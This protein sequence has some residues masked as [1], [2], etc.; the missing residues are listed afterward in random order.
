[1]PTLTVYETIMYSA[2]LRLPRH[3]SYEDKKARV[4][5]TMVEL[6]ILHIA[7]RRIGTAG[8]RGIS[9]GEKRRVSIACELVT[10]ASVLF[11]DEPT[12]GE[13]AS[14]SFNLFAI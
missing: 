3:M 4:M 6:D 12:S 8:S 13:F 7:N 5:E 1:M 14:T 2:L 11:L 10:G 9:G